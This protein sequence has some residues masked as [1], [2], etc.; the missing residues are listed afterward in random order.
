MSKDGKN[1]RRVEEKNKICKFSIVKKSGNEWENILKTHDDDDIHEIENVPRQ[2]KKKG[3]TL[4][5][6]Y[7]KGCCLYVYTKE[8]VGDVK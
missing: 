3:E 4:I 5:L 8:R 1:T 7:L 2:R 6:L